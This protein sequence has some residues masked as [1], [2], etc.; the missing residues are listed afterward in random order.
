MEQ[1]DKDGGVAA[2][3]P[4]IGAKA[5]GADSFGR[6]PEP[7]P[8]IQSGEERETEVN[9]LRGV[10]GDLSNVLHG[11]GHDLREPIRTITSFSSLLKT[12]TSTNGDPLCREYIHFIASA[13]QRMSLLVSGI[14]DYA[15]LLEGDA[16]PH[17][18]V[19][20]NAVLQVA[21]ANLQMSIEEAH[22]TIVHDEL[23]YVAGD[24]AQL[25]QL[26]QN[27]ISNAIKYHGSAPPQIFVKADRHDGGWLFSIED[28]GIGIDPRHRD[29]LFAPFKRLHGQDIPGAGLGLAICRSVV[30]RHGGRIWVDSLPG[31]GSAFRF[32]LP[33]RKDFA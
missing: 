10:I 31:K 28:N 5:P 15:R 17:A 20:M 9:R 30:E 33:Y 4:E 26:L 27:L 18:R 29:T 16:K 6:N 25:I 24:F 7:L 8:E 23:P 12:Q 19:D 22:A 2:R 11:I 3:N 14:L 13:A 1:Q 32:T 21:V